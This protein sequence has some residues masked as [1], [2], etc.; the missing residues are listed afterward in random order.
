MNSAGTDM[1][2]RQAKG[3]SLVEL[4][5]AVTISLILLAG[6]VQIYS[7]SKQAYRIGDASAR[8][9]ENARFAVDHLTKDI[10]MAGYL[11]CG[12][13]GTRVANT[14]NNASTSWM[15]NFQS[16]LIGYDGGNSTF[17]TLS[18]TPLANTDAIVVLQGDTDDSFVVTKHKPN[19]AVIQL[20][21]KHNI[22]QGEI[23]IISD[24]SQKAGI[25][26]MSNVNNNNT[27]SVVG[28]NQG[29]AT[30]PG[31]CTKSLVALTP[32]ADCSDQVN[33]SPVT[34]G[35]GSML[36]RM[37]SSIYYLASNP[38]GIPSLYRES[39]ISGSGTGTAVATNTQELV[40][41]VQDM[42][43]QYGHDTDGDG[44]PN[45]YQAA[46]NI[47]AGNWSDVVAVRIQL[48]LRSIKEASPQEQAYTFNGTTVASPGDRYI[49]RIVSNT[50]KVRNRGDR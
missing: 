27:I 29:N 33:I 30:T 23:L 36:M 34:Y 13:D 48:L 14:L 17:P 12:T 7:S 18:K 50:I 21:G 46:H 4:M 19:S 40:E 8:V 37:K 1:V 28:H 26:Q 38:D 42:Q 16:P 45:Q 32:Y 6:V 43:I 10:R 31:N 9:Q 25:F 20:S 39:L 2:L 24:C 5:V 49:R 11:G 22:K 3:F 44:I 47:G 41:G 15:L 35:A